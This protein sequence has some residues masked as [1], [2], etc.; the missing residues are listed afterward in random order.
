MHYPNGVFTIWNTIDFLSTNIREQ[1][2]LEKKWNNVYL[3]E[4]FN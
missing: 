3:N 1:I 2:D 4:D